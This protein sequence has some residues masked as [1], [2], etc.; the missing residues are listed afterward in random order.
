M[1]PNHKSLKAC[2]NF[3][4]AHETFRISMG[5]KKSYDVRQRVLF[6]RC[7][8]SAAIRIKDSRYAIIKNCVRRRFGE[9]AEI[10]FLFH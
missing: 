4:H 5:Y 7:F 3:F 2:C 9:G 8:Y 6:L 10:V 1:K